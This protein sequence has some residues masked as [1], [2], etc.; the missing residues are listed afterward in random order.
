M[1]TVLGIPSL[2]VTVEQDSDAEAPVIDHLLEDPNIEIHLACDESIPESVQQQYRE[3]TIT[4]GEQQQTIQ[5]SAIRSVSDE[6]LRE[7]L[8]VRETIQRG[9]TQGVQEESSL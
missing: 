1:Y 6:E 8:G 4:L 2:R 3:W 9:S 7:R 5:S